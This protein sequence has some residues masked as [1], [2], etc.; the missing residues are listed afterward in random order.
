MA[1]MCRNVPSMGECRGT[2]LP[3]D[4]HSVAQMRPNAPGCTQFRPRDGDFAKRSH[5][6]GSALFFKHPMP[7]SAAEDLGFAPGDGFLEGVAAEKGVEVFL[8]LPLAEDD[9]AAARSDIFVKVRLDVAGETP[10]QVQ[11]LE[12]ALFE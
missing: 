4:L 6:G 5:G 12:E 3:S 10:Q 9:V 11:R 1:Q 7:R 2:N 8:P